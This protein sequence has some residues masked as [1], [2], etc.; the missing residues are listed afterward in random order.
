M[1]FEVTI[2][3]TMPLMVA[4]LKVTYLKLMFLVLSLLR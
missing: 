1:L 3:Q 4:F 2:Y